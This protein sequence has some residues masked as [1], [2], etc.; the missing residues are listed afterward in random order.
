MGNTAKRYMLNKNY[1]ATHVWSESDN[2]T[3]PLKVCKRQFKKGD[4]IWG[5]LKHKNN[6]PCFVIVVGTQGILPLPLSVVDEVKTKDITSDSSADGAIKKS[7]AI[8]ISKNPKVIYA[9]AIVFGSLAGV[10]I[11]W[12]AESKGW[13]KP[14]GDSMGGSS[15]S[16]KNKIY[17]AAIGATFGA[18]LAFRHIN[19]RKEKQKE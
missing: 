8:Q 3:I 12:F 10:L 13:I 19:N 16:H 6:Q 14:S 7:P 1:V 5:E 18:F 2:P 17:G 15:S 9:D 11:A 4:V